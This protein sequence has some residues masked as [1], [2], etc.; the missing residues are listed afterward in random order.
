MVYSSGG[1]IGSNI[2]SSS[3]GSSISSIGSSSIAV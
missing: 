3:I 1:S 2:G